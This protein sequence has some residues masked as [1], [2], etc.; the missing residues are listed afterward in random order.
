M[1]FCCI[2][3]FI[4]KQL[5]FQLSVLQLINDTKST[6]SCLMCLLALLFLQLSGEVYTCFLRPEDKLTRHNN[7]LVA[8]LETLNFQLLSFDLN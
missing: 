7:L 6:L 8:N 5:D 2:P 4:D 1:Y 3:C